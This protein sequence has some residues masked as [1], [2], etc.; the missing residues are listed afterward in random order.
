MSVLIIH[1]IRRI[2][3]MS[4][5]NVLKCTIDGIP[6]CS[7]NGVKGIGTRINDDGKE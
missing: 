2:H 7:V 5:L 6:P 3:S 4:F 1:I